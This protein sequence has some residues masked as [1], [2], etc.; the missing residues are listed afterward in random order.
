MTILNALSCGLC[1]GAVYLL[2]RA[3]DGRSPRGAAGG[4]VPPRLELRDVP[5]HRQRGHPA[6]LHRAVRVDGAGRRMA[7]AAD[8]AAGRRGIGAVLARLA[9]GMAADVPHP[10]RPAGRAVALRGAAGAA[11]GLDRAVPC[12]HGSDGHHHRLGVAGPQRCGRARP[13]SSGPARPCARSGRASPGPR[14]AICGTAW[15]PTCWVP[16][17]RRSPASRAGTSGAIPRRSGCWR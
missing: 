5:R 15:W 10:A 2:V 1:L 8:G 3:R 13:T 9:D 4:A 7:G 17:W 6:Q 11:A 16:A 12:R 14:S